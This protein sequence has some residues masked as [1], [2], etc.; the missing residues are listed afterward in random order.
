MYPL[1]LMRGSSDTHGYELFLKDKTRV[2][3]EF[4]NVAINGK[5]VASVCTFDDVL[6]MNQKALALIKTLAMPD[7]KTV[8]DYIN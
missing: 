3:V 8:G 5:A 1:K 7:G 6:A 2:G 4:N